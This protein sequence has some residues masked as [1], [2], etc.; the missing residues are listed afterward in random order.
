MPTGD[1]GSYRERPDRSGADLSS[2]PVSVLRPTPAKR[3][4]TG[5]PVSGPQ[6]NRKILLP[7]SSRLAES[8]G[9]PSPFSSRC[10]DLGPELVGCAEQGSDLARGLDVGGGSRA[11]RRGVCV[12]V[13][14]PAGP[15]RSRRAGY[16]RGRQSIGSRRPRGRPLH[17]SGPG[18][19]RIS[20]GGPR[21]VGRTP[22]MCACIWSRTWVVSLWP[23]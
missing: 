4:G 8:V 12:V 1:Q 14:T 18:W 6:P 13:A 2:A 9:G 22:R 17:G 5:R 7:A 11:G 3:K 21:R 19:A 10:P 23:T 20:V 15:R 16:W